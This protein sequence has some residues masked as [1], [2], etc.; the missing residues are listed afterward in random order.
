MTPFETEALFAAIGL[1]PILE[2]KPRLSEAKQAK[3]AGLPSDLRRR[4]VRFLAKDDVGPSTD[5][6]AFD[7]QRVLELVSEGPTAEDQRALFD[8]LGDDDLADALHDKAES[9]T[10][11]ANGII[12]REARKLPGGSIR[13]GEPDAIAMSDFR[14]QWQVAENPWLVMDDLEDGSLS[15]DQVQTMM[16]HFPELYG[17]VRQAAKDALAMTTA[18]KGKD[19][20]PSPIKG[21]LLSTLLQEDTID[22]DLASAVQ[23]VY[24]SDPQAAGNVPKPRMRKPPPPPLTPGQKAEASAPTTG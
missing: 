19:W 18:R 4:L 23:A 22:L 9:I 6:P 1:M 20:E 15:D 11:W 21:Q 12:P 5:V 8:L 17:E 3:I 10:T 13:Q 14:R 7:Y 2:G 24:S 16:L